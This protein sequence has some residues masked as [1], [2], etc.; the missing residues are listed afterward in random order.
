MEG[1]KEARGNDLRCKEMSSS[2]PGEDQ[3]GHQE[4]FIHKG[5]GQTL[6]W[7]AQGGGR[8]AISRGV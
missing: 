4:N 1:V 3:T 7:A 6:E 5:S 2:I 8:I